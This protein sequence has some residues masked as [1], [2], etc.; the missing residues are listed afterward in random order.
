MAPRLAQ[1][2]ETPAASPAA[3]RATPVPTPPPPPPHSERLD[4]LLRTLPRA[5]SFSAA[6]TRIEAAWGG[7]PLARTTLR[8]HLGQLRALG[9]PAALE[10]F[11]PSRRDTSF[12]ALLRLDDRAALVAAGDGPPIEAPLAQVDA[13]WTR[14]AVVFWPE[15]PEFGSSREA[16]EGWARVALSGLGYS[17][18]D[19][20]EAVKRFQQETDL[21]P[22]GL[23]GSRTRMALF[24]RSGS[25][26]PLDA[27]GG[28]P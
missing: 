20:P 9:L 14:D 17:E 22:D 21:V 25:V 12:V 11:H 16:R 27:G 15:P 23:L 7:R 6:A 13:L 18:P 8:T 5:A 26:R 3:P 1:A 10:T 4:A 24:A 19:L 28:Q 2:P